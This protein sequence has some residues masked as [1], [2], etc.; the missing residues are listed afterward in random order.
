[1]VTRKIIIINTDTQHIEKQ[2]PCTDLQFFIQTDFYSIPILNSY[3]KDC[4]GD[5][6]W[7]NQ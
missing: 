5:P 2:F 6:H 3:L 1:M 7:K 4:Q